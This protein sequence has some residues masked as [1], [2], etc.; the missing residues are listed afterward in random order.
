MST[1][2]YE[3]AAMAQAM[4]DEELISIM[5]RSRG[6]KATALQKAVKAEAFKRELHDLDTGLSGSNPGAGVGACLGA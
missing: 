1:S 6:E 4:L 3:C 5:R 2:E